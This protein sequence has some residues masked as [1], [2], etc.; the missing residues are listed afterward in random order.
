MNYARGDPNEQTRAEYNNDIII[1]Y[2][3]Y[4]IVVRCTF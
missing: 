3:V 4:Y 2:N 1:R